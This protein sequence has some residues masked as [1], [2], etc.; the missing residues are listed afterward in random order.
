MNLGTTYI[1]VD[2]MQ[3]S[4]AFYKALLQKEPLYANEDRWI[5]FDCGNTLSLYNK[6]YDEKIISREPDEHFNQAY[7][8][9]F[10]ADKGQ[11]RNNIIIL[12]F[13]VDDL[14]QEHERLLDL[15]IGKVSDLMYVNVHMPYWYFNIE[16][17]DGNIIEITGRLRVW[18]D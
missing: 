1:C 8:D 17:P 13:E 9:D 3:K 10:F 11:A 5:T 16:D 12:N 6:H 14:K 18:Q 15:N 2:D 7:I 4:L